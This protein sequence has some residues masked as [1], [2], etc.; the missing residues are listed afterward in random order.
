MPRSRL[1][2]TL[3]AA[4]LALAVVTT[5]GASPGTDLVQGIPQRG[6]VI[7]ERTA[8]VTL[9]Q[10][11]DLAC[12]HCNTYMKLAFPTIVNDYVRPGLVKVDFRGLGIVTRASE[13]ALR[14]V[15][16]AGRQRKLWQMT[17]VFYENQAKLNE[18]ATDKGV[19]RLARGIPGLNANQLILDSKSLSVR[20]Q[21]AAHAVEADRRKVPGTP[22]FFIKVGTNAPKLVRPTAYSGEAFATLLD[23]ALGR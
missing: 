17:E 3:A 18:I 15:L 11:E 12:T 5:V 10:F 4:A 16:A 7:G 19:R 14:F 6:T 9:I 20:K 2:L 22:W 1:G 8:N 21:A 13:P 23:E